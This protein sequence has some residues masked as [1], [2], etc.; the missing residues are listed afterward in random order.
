MDVL[1]IS[2]EEYS[3]L[4]AKSS[5]CFL[6]SPEWG[7]HKKIDGYLPRYFLVGS[8]EKNSG[9]GLFMALCKKY[10]IFGEQAYIPRPRLSSANIDTIAVALKKR[11]FITLIDPDLGD[12]S[13]VLKTAE[14]KKYKLSEKTI[15]PR[16]TAV[17]NL[18]KTEE[19]WFASMRKSTRK[20]VMRG[21]RC[22]KA[23]KICVS[24]VAGDKEYAEMLGVL[25]KQAEGRF[26][27][28]R[29]EYFLNMRRVFADKLEAFSVTCGGKSC[30]GSVGIVD[31]NAVECG[32]AGV[33]R[34]LY[35][36]ICR[37]ALA[38]YSAGYLVKYHQWRFARG[39]G[40]KA[41]DLWGVETDPSHPWYGFSQFKLG[42]GAEVVEYPP[43]LRRL[44]LLRGGSTSSTAALVGFCRSYRYAQASKSLPQASSSDTSGTE[45][46]AQARS[47][48]HLDA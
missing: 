7:E 14:G 48:R 44:N 6:Q 37:E 23:G 34:A 16:K 42:F 13:E 2:K 40:L 35:S 33:Y 24:A 25:V 17:I 22:E 10:P 29:I 18:S 9:N 28:R 19:E 38:R 8:D 3:T 45:R 41:L 4:Y 27:G 39:A 20:Q 46:C 30:G 32:K 15:Q 5:L 36:G 31:A 26:H 1:E 21:L 43:Q 12:L 11:F 47:S